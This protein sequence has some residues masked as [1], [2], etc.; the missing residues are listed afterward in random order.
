M[1]SSSSFS[2]SPLLHLLLLHL[3]RVDDVAFEV[4]QTLLTGDREVCLAG[5]YTRILIST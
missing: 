4:C 3:L 2:S 1:S 5:A